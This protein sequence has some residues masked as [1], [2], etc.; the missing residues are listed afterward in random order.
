MF[1][2]IDDVTA[3]LQGVKLRTFPYN[4]YLGA[5]GNYP[6]AV[7]RRERRATSPRAGRSSRAR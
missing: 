5:A 3:A 7:Y 2:G 1:G 6:N 4:R